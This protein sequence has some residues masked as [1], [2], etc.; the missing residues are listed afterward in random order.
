MYPKNPKSTQIHYHLW[1]TP[2]LFNGSGIQSELQP[3]M[4]FEVDVA[5]GIDKFHNNER[6]SIS[7]LEKKQ[8]SLFE[9]LIDGK[10]SFGPSEMLEDGITGDYFY[11]HFSSC[12]ETPGYLAFSCSL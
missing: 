10:L 9:R 5:G 1:R 3:E 6:F 12:E 7:F 4:L 2:N 8:E 11:Y